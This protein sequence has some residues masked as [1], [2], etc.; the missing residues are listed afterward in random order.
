MRRKPPVESVC[1]ACPHNTH[2]LKPIDI[3]GVEYHVCLICK[4]KYRKVQV[5]PST[6]DD[7]GIEFARVFG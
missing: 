1:N 7:S 4:S 5:R 2:L 3:K 6:N